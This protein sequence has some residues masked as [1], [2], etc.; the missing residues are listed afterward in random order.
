MKS[1]HNDLDWHIGMD[2]V[3]I[4]KTVDGKI[5]IPFYPSLTDDG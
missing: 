1:K 3:S 4:P 5:L 2:R